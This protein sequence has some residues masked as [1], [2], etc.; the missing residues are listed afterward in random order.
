MTRLRRRSI[1]GA[2]PVVVLLL[3]FRGRPGTYA[4]DQVGSRT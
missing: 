3:A 2:L 1:I 4:F